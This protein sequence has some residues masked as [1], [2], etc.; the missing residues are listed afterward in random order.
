MYSLL[1]KLYNYVKPSLMAGAAYIFYLFFLPTF[2]AD[3]RKN[4]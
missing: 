4:K 1:V 2:A 3:L